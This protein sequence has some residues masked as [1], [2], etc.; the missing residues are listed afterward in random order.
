MKINKNNI[1]IDSR[2]V[3]S[4]DISI[5]I[6]GTVCDGH[7]YIKE[8]LK[9]GASRVIC[10]ML[11][12]DL[13]EDEKSKVTR[14]EN[15][16]VALGEIAKEAFGDPSAVL[17]VHGVTGTNGKTTTVFL[18]DSIL[19]ASGHSSGLVST[20]FT[21]VEGDIVERSS[22]TTPDQLTLNRLLARMVS[23]GK[24][25]ASVEISSHALSQQRV[26]GIALDS[27]AFTNITPEHLDYH[28]DMET[29]FKDKS[30]IFDN[31]KEGG[32]AI[33]NFDDPMVMS[34]RESIKASNVITFGRSKGADLRA[35]AI[36][37]SAAGT[38]IDIISDKFGNIKVKTELIGMHNVYNALAA[39]ASLLGS[40]FTLEEIKKGLE[41]ARRVPGRLERIESNAPFVTF[42]DYAHT[43]DALQN[44]LKCLRPMT[45]GRLVCVFGCGG[46][47]DRTKRPVM[48][49]IAGEICDSVI[50]TSDNP[51]TEEASSI[52][53]EIEKGMPNEN[54]YS[55]ISQR[56]EAIREALKAAGEGDIVLIAGK[57][58]EDYQIIGK[59][60]FHFD[61]KEV[62]QDVLRQL[63]Y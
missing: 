40:G 51:R 7:D 56:Q 60:K 14:V 23:S 61:D 53:R 57:G 49:A 32:T 26:W 29:Y 38:D 28:G 10:Q 19:E 3:A 6:K 22:M 31:L 33:L 43:P 16:R 12:E 59:E 36:N 11:P 55:I 13:S 58:H 34:L 42:V 46:D 2:E 25:A 39:A 20:V 27:A 47:R 44:V 30:R 15:T 24:E 48:G 54:N 17:K 63:G 62:A 9:K 21:K 18:I 5:A 45:K 52:L 50:L 1:K 41:K 37:M 8:V 35:E 4:G